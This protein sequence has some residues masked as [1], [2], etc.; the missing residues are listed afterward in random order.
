MAAAGS[1]SL[2]GSGSHCGCTQECSWPVVVEDGMVGTAAAAAAAGEWEDEPAVPRGSRHGSGPQS[3][4]WS[5]CVHVVCVCV[6]AQV[7]CVHVCE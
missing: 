7:V 2:E 6:C 3:L 1:S 5:L 4:T